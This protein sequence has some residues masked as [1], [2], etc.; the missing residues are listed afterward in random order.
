MTNNTIIVPAFNALFLK[1]FLKHVVLLTTHREM[2]KGH[3]CY[4][5]DNKTMSKHTFFE[6]LTRIVDDLSHDLPAELRYQR[7]LDGM[8]QIF[9]CD[10][11]ALLQLD[12]NTLQ[13]LAVKGL[14]TDTMGRRF[15]VE[16]HPRLAQLLHSRE[17]IRFA[18]DSDLPDPYDGLVEAADQQL[19][20]HD[21]MGA[22]LRINDAPW[23]LLTLD[24]MCPDTFNNINPTELRTFISL[25]EAAIKAAN[26]I[27]AL[28][29]RAEREHQVARA[30]R[31]D[32]QNIEIVGKSQPIKQLQQEISIVAQ[33][34][35][36][37]L[38]LGE[39]GVGKELVARQIHRL[40]PRDSEPLVYVNCAAL[41]ENIAESELFGHVKGAFSGAV[42]NRSGKFELAD[43]GTLFLDEIGELPLSIQAKMLRVLQS[44][45]IQRVGDDRHIKVDVRVVAAT[46]RDL[47]Q[48]VTKGRFRADLYHRLSVYPVHVPALRERSQDVFLLA[49]YFLEG[50]Q[51]RFG[52]NGLRLAPETKQLLQR[53]PW[54]GNVRE[55]EHLLSRAALKAI[56]DQGREK[57]SIVIDA[58]YLDIAEAE[59]PNGEAEAEAN[60]ETDVDMPE[61]GIH[62]KEAI[63]Q[64]QRQL[65]SDRLET[66]DGNLAAAARDLGLNRSNFY[67]LVKRLKLR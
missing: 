42:A 56:T 63:D 5:N 9:P 47:Q 22:S 7:L 57:R 64:F 31:E 51:K 33:S 10:A 14:S 28:E 67:R 23:G 37:V 2:S 34:N 35:L 26:R 50:N 59:L 52:V 39:T 32:E 20:V 43:G 6:V 65:I 66:H 29:A 12:G 19:H 18:A 38:L 41:P 58:S 21:C 17:P 13:P 46:N 40:S 3:D 53:Y 11:A 15:V 1:D 25:T 4:H 16:E 27:E 48:E 30:L 49:G 24:A 45:E 61:P 55:L 62:L 60:T 44:G 36:T 8:E 54:P